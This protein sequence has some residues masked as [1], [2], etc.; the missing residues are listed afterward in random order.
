MTV[1]SVTTSLPN[2]ALLCHWCPR[3]CVVFAVVRPVAAEI[4]PA[5][6]VP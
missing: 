1:G 2:R 4:G 5:R 3:Y 6:P